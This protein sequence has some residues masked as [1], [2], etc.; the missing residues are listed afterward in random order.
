MRLSKLQKW[1]LVQT[2][3]KTVL[4]DRSNLK[5]LSHWN[6]NFRIKKIDNDKTDLYWKY[7]FRAEVLLN[8]F[9][10]ITDNEKYG[11]QRFHHFKGRNNKEQVTLTRSLSNLH[12]KGLIKIWDGVHS[13]WQG[14]TI[15]ETG[16]EKALMLI[17]RKYFL[18]INNKQTIGDGS[19]NQA[20]KAIA[21]TKGC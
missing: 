14:I 5:L 8:Y 6:A 1:I 9:N 4:F 3:K 19:L 20:V 16:Q 2:Y 21:I 11:F 7:L 12:D 10:C 17:D 15:T 13:S 18:S